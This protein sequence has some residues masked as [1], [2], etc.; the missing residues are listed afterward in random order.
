MRV[1]AKSNNNMNID[2][3][4]LMTLGLSRESAEIIRGRIEEL[5]TENTNL[6]LDLSKTRDELGVQQQELFQREDT[7]RQILNAKTRHGES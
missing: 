5:E 4:L 2:I 7:I 6:R 3:A 1:E